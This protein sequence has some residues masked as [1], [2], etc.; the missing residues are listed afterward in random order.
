MCD[1]KTNRNIKLLLYT[2]LLLL[3]LVQSSDGGSNIKQN[4]TPPFLISSQLLK[5]KLGENVKFSCPTTGTGGAV[6]TWSWN[7]RLISAG[8]MKV[9]TDDRIRVVDDGKELIVRNVGVEDRGDWTC[10]VQ[11][12]QAPVSLTHKLEILV[13]PSVSLMHTKPTVNVEEGSTATFE[14][15]AEGYPTPT[16]HWIRDSAPGHILS[17]GSSLSLSDVTPDQSG[18]YRCVATNTL[19]D[20]H[21]TLSINVLYKPRTKLSRQSSS[22]DGYSSST[23]LSCQVEAN[24]SAT[25]TLYK[26]SQIMSNSLIKSGRKDK[27]D[28][29]SITIGGITES[30]YGNYSCVARNSLGTST[31]SLKITGQP[32]QPHVTSNR[33]GLYTNN[34]KLIWSVWTPPTAKILNQS[35]LYR[36]IKKGVSSSQPDSNTSSWYNLA[37]IS[38]SASYS[39][40]GHSYHMLLTGLD[41][42]CQYEVR[43]RAMN[44]HGW[45]QLSEPFIFTTSSQNK[46]ELLSS[47]LLSS[48]SSNIFILSKFLISVMIVLTFL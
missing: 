23:L 14:C 8:A 35:I 29:Y 18:G 36:R 6:I 48:K 43:I 21:Q 24:P 39:G 5:S 28:I 13:A 15:S 22:R 40:S 32:D 47:S 42:D 26:D 25:V 27:Y 33:Q 16:V 10:T 11:L 2:K 4:P 9:Y 38:D 7:G 30:D 31:D 12:K 34:Y 46:Q 19:G 45:S 17:D 44:S 20:S 1:I 37:L 41:T 3:Q